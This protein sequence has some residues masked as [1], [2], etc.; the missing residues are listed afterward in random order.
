MRKGR[1]L[2]GNGADSFYAI[3]M[4]VPDPY[5]W[6]EDG[7]GRTHI[8]MSPLEVDRARKHAAA[9]E[10][11]SSADIAEQL[12]NHGAKPSLVGMISWLVAQDK[13]DV[14][15][16]GEDFPSGLM[17]RLREKKINVQVVDGLF[18]PDRAVKTK[19]E[20]EKQR[21]AQHLNEKGFARAFAILR[22]AE[23]QS[24]NSLNW[25]GNPLT[26]ELL[27]GE[28]NAE[29][30]RHG[31]ADFN[32]G[33]IVGC[34]AQGADPHERGHGVLKAHEFIIID[35][36]PT[37]PEGYVGDLTR[38]VIK[39]EASDWH[40]KVYEAV[41]GAQ[42]TALDMLRPGVNGADVHSAVEQY[43]IDHGFDTGLDEKGR[44]Y[45]FF[46]GTGHS[47]GLEVHDQH[48]RTLSRGAIDLKPGHITSVEPGLYYPDKGGVRI[49]DIVAISE[50][51][52]DNL[53]TLPKDLLLL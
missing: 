52:H 47:V 46:H 3:R 21:R 1:L 25:Q 4:Q 23:I 19:G 38:T 40:H 22:E 31:A 35:S 12:K 30:V 33:P 51:G 16:V 28:M 50:D 42:Q 37:G 20:V 36:F 41:K 13:P 29:L 43:F 17:L 34:G 7:D 15:E 18:F 8:I 9:D 6:Y 10:I 26:A 24:D 39:G 27:Q 44:N 49:E 5:P 11:H 14:V 32:G 53:T 48:L 45:G 2:Y